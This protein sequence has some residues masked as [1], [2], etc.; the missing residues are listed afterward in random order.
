[1]LRRAALLILVLPFSGCAAVRDFARDPYEPAAAP[2]PNLSAPQAYAAGVILYQR[3]EYDA[4]RREWG[5]CLDTSAADS[6]ARLDC[7]VALEKSAPASG[8]DRN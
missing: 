1:M 6:S 8:T 3:G 4:A 7:L 5:R 2:L